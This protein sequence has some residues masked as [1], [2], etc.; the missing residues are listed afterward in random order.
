MLKQGMVIKDEFSEHIDLLI[1]QGPL[2]FSKLDSYLVTATRSFNPSPPA[3]QTQQQQ[4]AA[5]TDHAAGVQAGPAVPAQ[6]VVGPGG[7][8]RPLTPTVIAPVGRQAQ[9]PTPIIVIPLL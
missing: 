5:G 1:A 4:A 3:S 9:A 8:F 2:G 6:G 7:V